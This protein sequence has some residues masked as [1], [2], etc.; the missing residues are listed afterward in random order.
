MEWLPRRR[1]VEALHREVE[2]HGDFA[3]QL[4]R[5]IPAPIFH[6]LVMVKRYAE[7]ARNVLLPEVLRRSQV[8]QPFALAIIDQSFVTPLSL[9]VVPQDSIM[10]GGMV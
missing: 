2:Q 8:A 9:N 1:F 7:H 3:G 6:A 5:R 4:G 10:Q